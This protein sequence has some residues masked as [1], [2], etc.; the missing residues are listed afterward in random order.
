[1]NT[2]FKAVKEGGDFWR[3]ELRGAKRDAHVRNDTVTNA[4]FLDAY[5]MRTCS[6][7]PANMRH[8]FQNW[9]KD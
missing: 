1:M 3:N 6:S 7:V 5:R 4:A 8:L 9:I 2:F